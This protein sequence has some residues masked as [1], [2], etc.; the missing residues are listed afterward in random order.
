LLYITYLSIINY[1]SFGNRCFFLFIFLCIL[2]SL[3]NP[4]LFT[5]DP[6]FFIASTKLIKKIYND[7]GKV[8]KK[9]YDTPKT[10]YQRLIESDIDKDVKERLNEIY[11]GLNMVELRNKIDE[12]VSELYNDVAIR[13]EEKS[14]E[15]PRHLIFI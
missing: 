5:N 2:F 4:T 7:N 12:K 6:N 10:P 11:R 14:K 8:I 3:V 1:M 13:N 15:F 9:I